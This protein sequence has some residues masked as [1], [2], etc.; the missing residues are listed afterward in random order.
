MIFLI[1]RRTYHYFFYIPICFPVLLVWESIIMADID[2]Q[3]ILFRRHHDATDLAGVRPFL[4]FFW[5]VPHA[6]WLRWVF[7]SDE[8]MARTFTLR[9]TT[10]VPS[11]IFV[12][13][14]ALEMSATELTDID[15]ST[16]EYQHDTK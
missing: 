1:Y 6:C 15:L 12:P 7:V 8:V 5:C 2:T 9:V 10:D 16:V 11:E 13:M 4:S 3:E 14:V